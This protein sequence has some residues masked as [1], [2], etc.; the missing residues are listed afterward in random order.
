MRRSLALASILSMVLLACSP[1]GSDTSD[2]NPPV[3]EPNP[4][5]SVT[6]GS[7]NQV[8][9]TRPPE[10]LPAA[11]RPV[12]D[13]DALLDY[14]IE[15]A[16]EQVG[17]WGLG[18][19]H[20]V[21]FLA[22]RDEAAEDTA[23]MS[24]EGEAGGGAPSATNVQVEGV[25]EGDFVK[26]V[27]DRLYVISDTQ[28]IVL[29]TAGAEVE[30]LGALQLG[31][32]AWGTQML[33]HGDRLVLMGAGS[34]SGSGVAEPTADTFYPAY[35][36][37]ATVTFVDVSDP[38]KPTVERKLTMDG[39]VVASRLVEGHLRVVLQAEPVGLAWSVPEGSGL[40][41]ERDATERNREIVRQSTIDNWLPYLVTSDGAEQT[42]LECG[43]LLLPPEP[44]G[45]G[46]LSI[47]DFDLD[48]DGD[49]WQ[50]AAVVASGSTVYA[51][52]EHTFV[53]TSRW[54]DPIRLTEPARLDGQV[55]RIHRFDTPVDGQPTYVASGDVPGFLLNQF[56]MDEYEG[57]L[58]VASTSAPWWWGGGDGDE[59]QSRVTVLATDGDQ[60]VE[61]GV[62]DGLGVTETIQAV[63]FMGPVGYVVTF[64]QTDPLYVIDLADP[65]N[66]TAAGELKIPGFS[67]Y[68]HPVADGRLL[69]VGQDADP[70]TG[71]VLGLQLSLFDVSD[72]SEPLRIDSFGIEGGG[73][74]VE[75]HIYSPVEGDHK[76]FTKVD[77]AGYVPYEGWSW[78]EAD[79]S[80]KMQMGVIE[81]RWS[82]DSLAE[83]RNLSIFAGQ[84][85][86]NEWA[87]TPQ[88]VIVKGDV[89][90]AIGGQGLSVIDLDRGEVTSQTRF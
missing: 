85:T 42:L 67:A 12:D 33:V 15:Q 64:R 84:P 21:D 75:G 80:E 4:A 82:G 9:L 46:T 50:A 61:T 73:E 23:A 71:M 8:D 30:R 57:H 39:S 68:L 11:L 58:R 54:F 43:D 63:R 77:D 38:A 72:P 45:L 25:D 88:R 24:A 47:L 53:A 13:C 36:N 69:G 86:G 26:A 90:Y 76:A 56:A 17:P 37:F 10:L 32:Q 89:A 2:P 81:V 7:G 31:E 29:S 62:V 34:S 6:D 74:A 52:L 28:L 27:G 5:P 49:A 51:N 41:A 1:S 59:S 65:A 78:N 87:L 60:L 22:G 44:S 14:F 18:G 20:G 40:R 83:S 19:G 55:T 16:L 79:A 48:E 3:D 35:S 70:E 66:P